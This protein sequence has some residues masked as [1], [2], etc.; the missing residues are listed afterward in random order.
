LVRAEWDA[1]E[2]NATSKT[3]DVIN[4]CEGKF[5]AMNHE[6]WIQLCEKA[7]SLQTEREY[8]ESRNRYGQYHQNVH[9]PFS[10]KRVKTKESFYWTSGKYSE[11]Q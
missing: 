8:Y 6:D 4:L 3:V 7:A 9:L 5:S 11:R 2:K 1:P 10:L